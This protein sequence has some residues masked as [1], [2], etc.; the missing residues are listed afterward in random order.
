MI[1]LARSANYDRN[2]ERH[3]YS[4]D[5]CIICG[6]PVGEKGWQ[7]HLG[8]GG[9]CALTEEEA[10]QATSGEMGYFPI[11]RNCAR[12]HLTKEQIAMYVQK[13]EG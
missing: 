2:V 5:C 3:G 8:D 11:G 9:L 6:K 13:G 10:Q 7:V 1:E 12:K 4:V